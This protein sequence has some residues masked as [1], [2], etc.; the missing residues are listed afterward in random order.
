MTDELTAIIRLQ[1]LLPQVTRFAFTA[2]AGAGSRTGWSG[3]GQG[4]VQAAVN[5][6]EIRFHESGHF[7][8]AGQQPVVM[9]NLYCWRLQPERVAL[10]HERRGRDAAVALFDLVA[11]DADTLVS[12]H[13]HQCAADAY[14]ARLHL[15]PEGFDLAWRILGPRK[16]ETL[17]YRYRLA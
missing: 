16:D 7:T 1:T 17:H 6:D 14:S 9:R 13:H 8:L 10:A 15:L 2:E 4:S 5:G 3:H 12:E 11:A